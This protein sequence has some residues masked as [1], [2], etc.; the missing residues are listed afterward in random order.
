MIR[1]KHGHELVFD[2]ETKQ[3]AVRVTSAAGHMVEL[4]DAGKAIRVTAAA[5]ATVSVQADGAITLTSKASITL[6][7][8]TVTLKSGSIA[9]GD[10]ATEPVVLGHTLTEVFAAH[11]HSNSAGPTTP[12]I[13]PVPPVP[14]FLSGKVHTA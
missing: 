14:P 5:G 2:D 8:P 11:T 12:P 3:A 6:D 4:D 13:P 7:A 9:L 10:P 1:T